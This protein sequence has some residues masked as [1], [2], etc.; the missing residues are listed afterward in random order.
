MTPMT[1]DSC[2]GDVLPVE[3]MGGLAVNDGACVSSGPDASASSP[4]A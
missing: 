2:E 1:D 4:L 3:D